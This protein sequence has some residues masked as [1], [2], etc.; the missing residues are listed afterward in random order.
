MSSGSPIN[1]MLVG[2]KKRFFF[3]FRFGQVKNKI[4]RP[5]FHSFA[6]SMPLALITVKWNVVQSQKEIL[7]CITRVSSKG[8]KNVVFELKIF[9]NWSRGVLVN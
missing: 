4:E 9:T 8:H 6:I 1:Y 5:T 2:N 7:C 3:F